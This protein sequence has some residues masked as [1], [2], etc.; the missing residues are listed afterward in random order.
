MQTELAVEQWS[1]DRITPYDNNPRK[2]EGAVEQ[3]ANSIK[4]FGFRQPVV[5]DEAGV[6]IA[7]HTR[8]KAAKYLGLSEV[9]VHVARGLTEAQIKAYRIAD[10]KTNE[11]AEWDL[12]L[13]PLELTALEELEFDIDQLGFTAAELTE[14]LQS[15]PVEGIVDPD[16]IPEPPD[17]PVTQTGDLWLL[18]EHRLL[19]GDSTKI[20]DVERVLDGRLCDA[21]VSDPPYGVDYVGKTKEALEVKNDDRAG[22]LILLQSALTNALKNTKKGGVW[23]VFAPSGPQFLEFATVLT[24]LEVWRQT[25]VWVKNTMVLGHSDYHY[26][27]ESIFYG[28]AP[29]GPHQAVPDRTQTT[30]WEYDKPPSSREHPTMKPV[31]MPVRMLKNSTQRGEIVFDPFMGSGT[32]IIAAEQTGRK[33]CG[34]EISPRYCDV[35]VKRWEEFTGNTAECVSL[36]QGVD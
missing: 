2:N 11:L 9:P 1:L 14:I 8:F 23:Y 34:I 10:N 22:L 4:E 15:E 27:H 31:A 7:G 28:W 35:I 29:G 30:F 19:C 33:A 5:V 32:T 17:E 26:R 20:E 36:E 25:L 21:V 13:L 16:E 12:D 6:I 24:K 3:V 18:G